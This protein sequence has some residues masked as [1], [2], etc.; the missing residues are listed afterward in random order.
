MMTNKKL[1]GILIFMFLAVVLAWAAAITNKGRID[2]DYLPLY[3][4]GLADISALISLLFALSARGPRSDTI[5]QTI[6]RTPGSGCGCGNVCGCN[7]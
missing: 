7:D 3:L 6:T 1:A 2:G 5:T 4:I